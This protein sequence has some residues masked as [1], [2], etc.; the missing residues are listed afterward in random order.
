MVAPP[1]LGARSG[2]AAGAATDAESVPG[3]V[4]ATGCARR[5]RDSVAAGRG[6]PLLDSGGPGSVDV[7]TG[8]GTSGG[9]VCTAMVSIGPGRIDWTAADQDRPRQWKAPAV[10]TGASGERVVGAAAGR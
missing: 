4:A 7:A 3:R 1:P 9:V 6:G 2:P 10:G 5:W 8:R